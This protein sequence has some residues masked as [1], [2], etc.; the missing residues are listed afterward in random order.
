VVVR[1]TPQGGDI[2]VR[3]DTRNG[4]R[5]FVL[6]TAA[7]PDQMVVRTREAA[8]ERARTFAKHQ[9]VRV[10]M[11][12]GDNDFTLVADFRVNVQGVREPVS[13]PDGEITSEEE[14]SSRGGD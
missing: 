6:R 3:Q 10:W 11:A 9:Q 1:S 13:F 5:V 7:F 4:K 8:L 2:V 14:W 12:N